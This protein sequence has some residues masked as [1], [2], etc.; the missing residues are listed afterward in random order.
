MKTCYRC[1]A[2]K[3]ESCFRK[4]SASKDGLSSSC[5]D[6]L[7]LWEV[8]NKAKRAS[9]KARWRKDNPEKCAAYVWKWEKSNRLASRAYKERRNE[10]RLDPKLIKDKFEYHGNCCI[11]CGSTERLEVEHRKPLSR[12]G[13]G[14]LS[15]IAPACAKCNRRKGKK[16]EREFKN[17]E[18]S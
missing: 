3:S 11:Y 9:Q 1:K 13:S 14:L 16:T 5:K 8:K 15:N 2:E 7:R 18:K 6:C 12:G 10:R 17:V 4:R